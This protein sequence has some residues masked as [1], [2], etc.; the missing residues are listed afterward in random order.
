MGGF[1]TW[2]VS[3]RHPDLFAA[4]APVFGGADYHSRLSEEQLAAQNDIEEFWAD[5]DSSWSMAESLINTPIYVHHGDADEAVPVEWSR[6]GVRL[7]QRWGYDVRY[8]EYPGKRHEA[9]R[10][11]NG[12]LNFDWFLEHERN[13]DPRQVRI[14]SAELRNAKAFWV[15][16]KQ[17]A[18]PLDFMVVDAEVVDRNVIRLDTQNV[19]DVVLT[20][21]KAL[22]D[23]GKSVKVIWNG[24]AHELEGPE[25]R[26]RDRGYKPAALVKT[27]ALPGGGRDFYV[28]PF[29]VVIGTTSRDPEMNE[30]IRER[31]NRFIDAWKDWQKQPPRV[32]V[33]TEIGDAD[34]G[35][36]SLMLWGGPAEN[37]VAARLA[38]K[39]PV[40]LSREAIRLDGQDFTVRDAALQMLYPNPRNA[41]RYV[42]LIAANS[43]QGMFLAEVTP[44]RPSPWDYFIVDGHIPT[45]KQPASE[46]RLAVV[47][48][49]FD[50]RWRYA[51][52]FA[53]RGDAA[54]RDN[55]HV[56]RRPDKNLVIDPQV[57]E[58]YV[59]KFQV[60]EGPLA[61]FHVV[62]KKLRLK[63]NNGDF[64][65]SPVTVNRF[66]LPRLNVSVEF[67]RDAEGRANEIW[68]YDGQKAFTG[69]RVP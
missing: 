61:E 25:L 60:V 9:L 57:L 59:G 11:S 55:G 14:R 20:P 40:R 27:P 15:S 28:T 34:I 43:T 22:V 3:T 18:N 65:L 39:L 2:N 38:A 51:E 62:D 52:S 21:T 64:E 49:M 1:G 63:V 4:I 12:S 69:K 8:Q 24:V 26:L 68:A 54:I 58:S 45:P 5:N 17:G 47:S 6:Y 44:Q 67:L 10:V 41:S 7:L 53:V 42:W 46:L 23:P 29:A 33:D 13:P 66:F 16:V 35:R 30:L 32:F 50:P 37:A 56:I 48:G 19:L 36:Y 31:A